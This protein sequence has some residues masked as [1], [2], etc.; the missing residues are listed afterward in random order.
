LGGVLLDWRDVVLNLGLLID[1]K[2]LFD[3][4]V[5]KICSRVYDALHQLRLLKFMTPK[6]VRLKLCK[7]L[8]VPQFFY[9]DVIFS[10]K[11]RMD[12]DRLE[13]AFNNCTRYVFGLR[14]FDRL[15]TTLNFRLKMPFNLFFEYC[16]VT[17][18]FRLIKSERPVYLFSSL[19]RFGSRTGNFDFPEPYHVGSVLARGVRFY[20]RLP[21]AIKDSWSSAAFGRG[22]F[23]LY[24]QNIS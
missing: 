5:T 1:S 7:A 19:R 21:R 6:V 22:V 23:A 2:L 13:V 8:L 10:E 20:K 14:R 17:F 9:G 16:F 18:L 12:L 24:N 11:R 3:R 4:H 15:S